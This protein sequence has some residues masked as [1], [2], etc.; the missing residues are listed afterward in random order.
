MTLKEFKQ[1]YRLVCSDD[2]GTSMD[3]WF[4]CA[5][6]MYKRNMSMPDEWEYRA[7]LGNPTEKDSYFHPLF[8]KC[9]NSELRT[10]GNFLF[11]Y[12]QMLKYQGK[13]Y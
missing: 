9:K 8:G 12:C 13:N 6:F 4:E 10:I 7:G 5:G 1:E 2:W 11:R 3:A